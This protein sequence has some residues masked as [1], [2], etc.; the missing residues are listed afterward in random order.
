MK[1]LTYHKSTQ[2][3]P[4]KFHHKIYAIW[5]I[6]G[7]ARAKMARKPWY[8]LHRSCWVGPEISTLR[9]SPR[10]EVPLGITYLFCVIHVGSSHKCDLPWPFLSHWFYCSTFS[11]HRLRWF[12]VGICKYKQGYKSH[13]LLY[14]QVLSLM[15]KLF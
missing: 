3:S 5:L 10:M 14:I 12:S 8:L 15:E 2:K 6:F 4:G 7:C 1:L 9:T 13:D 11:W